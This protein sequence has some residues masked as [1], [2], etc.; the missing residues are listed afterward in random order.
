MK[1]NGTG[2][3]ALMFLNL[4]IIV[5]TVLSYRNYRVDWYSVFASA[6]VSLLVLNGMFFALR[7]SPDFAPA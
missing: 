5:G 1:I 6:G 7:R 3:L 4:A 2:N